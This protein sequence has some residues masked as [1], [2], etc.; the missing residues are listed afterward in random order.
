[1]IIGLTGKNGSGKGEAAKFLKERG[2]E[3]HS[4]SDALREE[5]KKQKKALSR[6]NLIEAGN[7]LRKAEGPGV[8]AKRILARLEIDR[9]YVIDS[10]RHPSEV[11]VFRSRNSFILQI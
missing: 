10:I 4:L 11:E 1:M 7:A 2:F 6:E 5:V 8:L 3:Y 9:H